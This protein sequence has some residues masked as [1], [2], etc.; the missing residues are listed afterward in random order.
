MH[1]FFN[2]LIIMELKS[3]SARRFLS[4]F[5]YYYFCLTRN[6]YGQLPGILN[7]SLETTFLS[8]VYILD[9]M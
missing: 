2:I 3:E 9:F 6:K 7:F 1:V 4:S 8:E 5:D